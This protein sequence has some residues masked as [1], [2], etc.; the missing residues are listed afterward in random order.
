MILTVTLNVAVDKL[1]LVDRFETGRVA[2]VTTCNATA[3]GKG[4][5]VSR[6]ISILGEEVVATGFI[7]GHSGRFVEDL[8]RKDGIRNEFIPVE[9][10][11]RTCIN[12]IDAAGKNTELLEPGPTVAEE[13][14]NRFVEQF[15]RFLPRCTVVTISGSL[16]VGCSPEFYARLIAL[17]KAAGKKVILD[18][19]GEALK[20]GLQAKP[21][22]VKPNKDE[23]G[24]LLG[25]DVTDVRQAADAARR[26][27]DSGISCAVVSLGGAGAVMACDQGTFQGTP[28]DVKTVNTVGCGDSMIGAFAVA[29]MRGYS[30]EKAL[31]LALEVSSANAMC[32]QTGFFYPADFQRISGTAS[33]R[34][35]A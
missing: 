17:V 21:T 11:S 20:R 28:P 12:I 3:G 22:L 26:L 4:L 19:S 30:M 8:L 32:R 27:H 5:N 14:Q 34:K 6:I 13:D 31:Q 35:L 18:T 15:S 24:A 10:E 23:A 25:T 16:P 2:R 9:G 33:V 1:Y 29:M 7:G